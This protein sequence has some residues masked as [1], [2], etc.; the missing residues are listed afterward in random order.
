MNDYTYA[1]PPAILSINLSSLA[2]MTGS[3]T[4]RRNNGDPLPTW[5]DTV[6]PSA[7]ASD[8]LLWLLPAQMSYNTKGALRAH[9]PQE[10]KS[11]TEFATEAS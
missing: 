6:A 4:V 8:S 3:P 1:D 5:K 7:S 2:V 9:V 11:C 10:S